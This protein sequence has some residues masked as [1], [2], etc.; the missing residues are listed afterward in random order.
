[1]KLKG[2]KKTKKGELGE[3]KA[4]HLHQHFA[5]VALECHCQQEEQKGT[6][7]GTGGVCE[8]PGIP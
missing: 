1:M 8:H 5:K 7:T 3:E 4:N 2:K 6:Q